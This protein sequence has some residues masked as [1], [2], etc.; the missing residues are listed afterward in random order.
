[1]LV[2]I[3]HCELSA[4]TRIFS[5]QHS[6]MWHFSLF[7][8]I[9][10]F[11]SRKSCERAQTHAHAQHNAG[12]L[13]SRSCD[14]QQSNFMRILLLFLLF[15][16]LWKEERNRTIFYPHIF[17]S[18]MMTWRLWS[19]VFICRRLKFVIGCSEKIC[20]SMIFFALVFDWCMCVW[21]WKEY[22]I[23]TCLR[24]ESSYK[25]ENTTCK[26]C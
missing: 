17:S 20:F 5:L 11:L 15:S 9:F 18:F 26:C 7:T 3:N 12:L 1:M 13:R 23:S 14:S 19:I 21:E 4:Y 6:W 25:K 2:K 8:R 10:Y 16:K 22:S 24:F